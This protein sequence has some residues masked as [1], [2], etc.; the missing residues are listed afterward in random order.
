[1]KKI[2]FPKLKNLLITMLM[3][4]AFLFMPTD[5]TKAATGTTI[6]ATPSKN[7]PQLG[8]TITVSITINNVQNL[9]GIDITLHWDD[10]ALQLL[11]VDSRLGVESHPDGVLHEQL[12]N[13]PIEIVQE[14]ISQET[15]IYH[16]VATSVNPAPSFNG[17]GNV[18]IITFNTTST[19][20]VKLEIESELADRPAPGETA[21]LI[22]HKTIS[23]TITVIPEFPTSITIVILLTLITIT[24][25]MLKK[26][27]KNSSRYN[28][29]KL[30][31]HQ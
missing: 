17:S 31:S 21:N 5:A 26:H 25:V 28:G 4:L 16:V 13:A 19:A 18:A 24:T 6:T 14:T 11:K 23:S 10:T 9:Y 15:G 12:P 7:T 27:L 3:L 1:M 8:E 2:C 22:E 20:N 29:Y 30:Y